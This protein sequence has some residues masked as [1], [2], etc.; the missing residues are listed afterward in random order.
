MVYKNQFVCRFTKVTIE[1]SAGRLPACAVTAIATRKASAA[2]V[3]SI[4]MIIFRRSKRSV[5]TPAG[6]VNINQG[7]RL[8]TA[9]VAIK[10]GDLVTAEANQGYAT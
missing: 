1:S 6:R 9:T 10:S 5:I 3:M 4:A 2:L 8:A 7:S